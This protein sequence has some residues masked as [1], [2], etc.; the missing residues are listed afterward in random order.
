M[1]RRAFIAYAVGLAPVARSLRAQTRRIP[2]IG[3]LWET[4]DTFQDAMHAFKTS[5]RGLGWIE[6]K[7]VIIEHRWT[8][9]RPERLQPLADELAR[10]KVDL[11][12]AP[13]SIYTGAAKRATATIPIVFFSHAD[14]V[15]SGHVM[16]LAHPEGNVTGF[17]LMMTETNVKL[18]ELLKDMN[19]GVTHVAAI[20]DPATPSHGPGLKAI[21]A[22]SRSLGLKLSAFPVRD[23]NQLDDTFTA[24]AK[25]RVDG[26]LVLSTPKYI[27]QGVQ[28]AQL[29]LKHKLATLFGPRSHVEEGG[30]MSY[31][32]DR[33]DLWRRGA[34]Y[35]DKILR[36]AKPADLPVQQPTKFELSMNRKT[37]QA[38]GLK[39]PPDFMLRVDTIIE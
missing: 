14:P 37:L 22:A 32:P 15:G 33:A 25:A 27:A 35:V 29:A 19:P 31:S 39:V 3:F 36:G 17:S 4:P 28:I 20:W 26:V 23:L 16:N 11:I 7:N 38:L 34:S 9:G 13:S 1:K 18:L 2:R 5:L 8:E 6:G 30:L 21:E 10:L 24:I 12:V